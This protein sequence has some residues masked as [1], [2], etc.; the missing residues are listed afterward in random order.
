MRINLVFI[1]ALLGIL[2]CNG[3]SEEDRNVGTDAINIPSSL[4]ESDTKLK[5]PEITF[6]KRV[7]DTGKISQGEILDFK[8]Q[9]TNTGEGPLVISSVDGS[10]GCTVLRNYPKGKIMPGEGG[11]IEVRFDSDN[12]W[13]KQTVPISVVTNTTPSLTQLVIETEIVVP[14][15]MKT[16]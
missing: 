4:N 15:Q 2:S 7:F 9:F 1:L 16:K 12:K 6:D 3:P 5:Q 10:C 13:G 11:T 14:D 8:W